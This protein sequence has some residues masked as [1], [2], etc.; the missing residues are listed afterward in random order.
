MA[1]LENRGG[2]TFALSFFTNTSDRV[3]PP[4]NVFFLS[5]VVFNLYSWW[6][7]Y[8]GHFVYIYLQSQ[9]FTSTSSKQCKVLVIHGR[10]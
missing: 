5:L 7:R 9:Q 6:I 10:L 4:L 8:L 2:K 3:G 1:I